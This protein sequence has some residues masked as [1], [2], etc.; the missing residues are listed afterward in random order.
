MHWPFFIFWYSV[1]LYSFCSFKYIC[2]CVLSFNNIPCAFASA[3]LSWPEI[4]NGVIYQRCHLPLVSFTNGVIY[5]QCYL[6]RVYK[7][8]Q[9]CEICGHMCASEEV[10]HREDWLLC[11]EAIYSDLYAV[12]CINLVWITKNYHEVDMVHLPLFINVFEDN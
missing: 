8:I 10:C 6:P 12:G 7:Q 4:T 1:Y 3:S 9:N 11:I 5:Q 2:L